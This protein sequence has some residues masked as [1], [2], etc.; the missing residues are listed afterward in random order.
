VAT[1]RYQVSLDARERASRKIEHLRKTFSRLGGEASVKTARQLKKL[2]REIR[3]IESAAG[4]AR[5]VFS[6]FVTGIVAA[7][8]SVLNRVFQFTGQNAGY[9]SRELDKHKKSIISLGIA[10]M[11]ALGIA[12]RFIQSKLDLADATKIARLAQDAAV[13]AGVNSSEAALGL[14]DA[15]IKQRPILLKQYGII[16]SLE[17]VYNKQAKT[18]GKTRKELTATE[19]RQGFL[20]E[21]LRQGETISG[22][23]ETAMEEVGKRITS[24]PRHGNRGTVY[25]GAAGSCRYSRRRAENDQSPG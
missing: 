16:L 22:A 13:I 2:Q 20:N 10:E 17:D 21:M 5:P 24:L 3:L 19:K 18:L 6:R 11:E 12:Q 7:R 4:K 8:I 9:A 23:Y 14:T 25:A 1:D 15:L